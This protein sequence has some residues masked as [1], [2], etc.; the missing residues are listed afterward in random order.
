VETLL[1]LGR[2]EPDQTNVYRFIAEVHD[3]AVTIDNPGHQT[4]FEMA[5]DLM[6]VAQPRGSRA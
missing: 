6:R 4:S 2:V 5:R 1:S 3:Q